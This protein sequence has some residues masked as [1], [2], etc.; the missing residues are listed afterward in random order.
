MPPGWKEN[1]SSLAPALLPKVTP[2]DGGLVQAVTSYIGRYLL[3]GWPETPKEVSGSAQRQYRR[4][5]FGSPPG[6]GPK[7]RIGRISPFGS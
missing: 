6:A 4:A 1:S 2:D 7:P 5:M 3:L